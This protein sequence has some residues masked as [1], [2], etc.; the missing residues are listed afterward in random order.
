MRWWLLWVPMTA[1]AAGDPKIE[2]EVRAVFNKSGPALDQC[3]AKYL[4]EYPAA[5][6]KATIAVEIAD[7]GK[8]V[9]ATVDTALSGARNLRYCFE[10][11]AKTWTFPPPNQE[12]VSLS[13][14]LAVRPGAKF[15]IP[16]PG[17]KPP[18]AE[19][20]AQPEGWWSFQ[21]TFWD[22]GQ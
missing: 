7:T 5:D 3:V 13:I 20:G 18:P 21:P 15:R 9:K 22:P 8:V 2:A 16:E 6:G 17:E 10:S 19:Q 1:L 12:K 14:T 11:V 4:A